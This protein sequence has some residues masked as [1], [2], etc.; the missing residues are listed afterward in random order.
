[1]FMLVTAKLNIAEKPKK[2]YCPEQLGAYKWKCISAVI[3]NVSEK[4]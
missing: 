1:M 4:N 2:F 3:L